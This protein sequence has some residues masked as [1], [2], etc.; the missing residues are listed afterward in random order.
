MEKEMQLLPGKSLDYQ[1]PLS[2][3]PLLLYTREIELATNTY[4]ADIIHMPFPKCALLFTS[5]SYS[6]S[7][8]SL[9]IIPCLPLP[10]NNQW[11][12]PT[13]CHLRQLVVHE[14]DFSFSRRCHN[15][16]KFIQIVTLKIYNWAAE[17]FS[18]EA[19][20]PT[21]QWFV[22]A[23]IVEVEEGNA[24]GQ[25]QSGWLRRAPLTAINW[26][27]CKKCCVTPWVS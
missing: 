20:T 15:L 7:T 27:G 12:S 23:P 16:F 22:S 18:F 10:M 19:Q 6:P 3:L 1:I 8:A 11:H 9:L 25:R 13:F 21:R 2:T 26:I 14:W 24:S 17:G 4:P 5:H